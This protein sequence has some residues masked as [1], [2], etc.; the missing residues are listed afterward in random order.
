MGKIFKLKDAITLI[1]ETVKITEEQGETGCPYVFIVGSGISAPEIL[2]ASGIIQH[3]KEQ[4][5]GRYKENDDDLNAICKEAEK[6][7]G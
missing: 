6:I 4:I 5:L 7:Y 3:C 2:T 1:W